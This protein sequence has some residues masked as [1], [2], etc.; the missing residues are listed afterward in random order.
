MNK[1]YIYTVVLGLAFI[2][3]SGFGK[4][5]FFY[6]AVLDRA[7]NSLSHVNAVPVLMWE[8]ERRTNITTEMS[9]V[10]VG[11]ND[12][13]LFEYPFLYYQPGDN[14]EK[15]SESEREL[16]RTYL[17]SGGF[18]VID[19]PDVALS[20]KLSKYMKT[21]LPAATATKVSDDSALYKS[22]YLINGISGVR[23][24]DYSVNALEKDGRF[25]VIII[26]SGLLEGIEK[27]AAGNP[28]NLSEEGVEM[29]D[30]SGI[31]IIM[32]ALCINYKSDQ[33]H[34]PFIMKRRR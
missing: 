31:N 26:S 9:A 5:S 34:I 21:V 23:G 25:A 33:V 28:V 17:L 12:K 3:L 11:L 13:S 15:F 4:T 29:A 7:G 32:Y 8:C 2:F 22:F 16:L 1:K 24:T 6:F 10:K 27:D 19:C 18:M 20:R 14:F 30:R